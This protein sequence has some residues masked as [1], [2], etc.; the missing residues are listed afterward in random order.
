MHEYKELGI[1]A[2]A[3]S[4]DTEEDA[5]AMINKF[6]LTF[7]VTHDVTEEIAKSIGAWW[8]DERSINQPSEFITM[9]GEQILS[10]TY[11]SG[12]IGRINPDLVLGFI[13][14]HRKK[15]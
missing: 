6:Y 3:A 2:I 13:K 4:A 11:S 8:E 1:D 14:Y 10:T 7:P 12:P 9:K 5:Q 15:R